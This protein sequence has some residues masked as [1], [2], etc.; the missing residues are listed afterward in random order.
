LAGD[1]MPGYIEAAIT[2]AT[3]QVMYY[4][5]ADYGA[6]SWDWFA[7][8]VPNLGELEGV[9]SRSLEAGGDY[10]SDTGHLHLAVAGA[11]S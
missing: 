4:A 5:L 6:E 10:A 9:F 1:A 7:L 8:D 11:S 2:D 3:P